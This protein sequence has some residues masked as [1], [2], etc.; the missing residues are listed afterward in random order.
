[1]KKLQTLGRS[2]SKIEQMK[3]SGGVAS[4]S[5]SCTQNTGSWT[6]DNG[7]QPSNVTIAK[8]VNAYC[9][10]TGDVAKCTG[11]TNQQ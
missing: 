5:C 7:S 3:I 1:M 11:C 4:C 6:Y 8:D 2:L 9:R 10:G